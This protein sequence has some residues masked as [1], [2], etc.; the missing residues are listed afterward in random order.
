MRINCCQRGHRSNR[1]CDKLN[2]YKIKYCIQDAGHF[3]ILYVNTFT[4][5]PRKCEELPVSE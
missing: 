1:S 5:C 3:I 4:E 2:I